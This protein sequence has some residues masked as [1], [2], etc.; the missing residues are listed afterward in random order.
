MSDSIL[1]VNLIKNKGGSAT[2]I[3]I[4]NSNAD[5]TMNRPLTATLS[6]TSTVPA[7]VGGSMH[8]I[9][10]QTAS[11]VALL[12]FTSLGT[13][14]AFTNLLFVFND[15]KPVSDN[16][17]F[18]SRVAKSGT[19]YVSAHYNLVSSYIER[20]LSSGNTA[21]PGIAQNSTTMFIACGNCGNHA[22][23]NTGISG[24]A[25]VYHHQAASGTMKRTLWN[26]G[27]TT[28]S[29]NGVLVSGHASYAVG[30]SVNSGP[31]TAIKFE[32]SSGNI[33]SGSITMY[34]V[35]DA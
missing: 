35:K 1:Q 21:G 15:V 19:T 10:K 13:H 18:R 24:Q 5:V 31:L 30:V 22:T 4:D 34:G 2:G 16:V 14:S 29:D 3:T 17:T 25:M 32:Y 6:S 8:L 20:N 26:L 9:Q 7:S 28:N 23:D 11:D 33:A 12:E 27:Y